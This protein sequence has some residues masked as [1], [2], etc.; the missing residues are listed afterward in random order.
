ME[1]VLVSGMLA[2][3]KS[4]ALRYLQDL[5]YYCIDNFPPTLI[6]SLMNLIFEKNGSIPK[7]ALVID[8]RVD[9]F[10]IDLVDGVKYL[11]E[12]T[13]LKILFIDASDETLIRRYKLNKRRH[14]LFENERIEQSIIK[15]RKLLNEV[16]NISNYYIDTSEISE[17]EMEEK[18]RCIFMEDNDNASLL[19]DLLSFGYKYGIPK[20]ADIVLDVRFL[21]NPYYID[22]LKHLSGLNNQVY[23]YIFTSFES[24]DFCLKLHEMISFFIMQY[25]KKDRRQLVIAIGCS[26]GRHRSVAIVEHIAKILKDMD[27]ITISIEHRDID[28]DTM[29]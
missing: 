24:Q 19:V 27:S 14:L 20:D 16:Y 3:G 5:G 26:G 2:S 13:N 17:G 21:P 1:V 6:P 11:K 4:I 8:V 23:Q 18:L 29:K 7:I 15:E 10:I 28:K 22:E 9:N 25:L 12:R